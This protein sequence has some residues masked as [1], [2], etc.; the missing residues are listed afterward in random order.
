[1]T[2]NVSIRKRAFNLDASPAWDAW[3]QVVINVDDDTQASAGSDAGRTIEI[4]TPFGTESMAQSIL[5]R[6]TNR[7]LAYQ[8]QPY[9]ADGALLDPAAEMGDSVDVN[10]VHG[11]IFTNNLTFSR[12]MSADISDPQDEEINHEYRFES[13][14]ERKFKREV[15]DVKATLLIQSN[16]IAAKVDNRQ[17]NQSFGWELL[18]DHW[19]VISNGK[20]VFRVDENGGT[21]AGN[22]AAQTGT[23]GGFTISATAI[24]NNLSAFGGSQ[25]SGVYLGTDG[26]QLGQKFKVDSGGN[27]KATRLEVDTLVINGNNVSANTLNSR[28]NSAYT[29]TTS[30]GFCYSASSAW[31]N[32]VTKNAQ[33]YPGYF[34]CGRLRAMSGGTLYGSFTFDADSLYVGTHKVT[35]GSITDGNGETQYVLKWS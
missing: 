34:T 3:T 2:D 23:I 4:T 9:T 7:Q 24:Y 17:D 19:S 12:L 22:V 33:I 27:A 21:F 31:N 5:A 30:G 13:P 1:M 16:L 8:Y 28:A 20:E 29:S 25:T 14:S 10:G 18:Q 35:R 6:I 26:I 11:G 15:G 32:A